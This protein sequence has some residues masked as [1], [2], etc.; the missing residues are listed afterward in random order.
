MLFAIFP[1]FPFFLHF[2]LMMTGL[3]SLS[4]YT[5]ETFKPSVYIL[6]NKRKVNIFRLRHTRQTLFLH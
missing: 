2:K 6:I 3:F 1:I 4:L 5:L